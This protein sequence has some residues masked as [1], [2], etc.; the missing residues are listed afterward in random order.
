MVRQPADDRTL[1][2]LDWEP[3][4]A[5]VGFEDGE[6]RGFDPYAQ[7]C[8]AMKLALA[9]CGKSRK[10]VAAAMS[11]YLGESVSKAMLDAYVSEGR[12][13][14]TINVVRVAAFIDATGDM[15]LLA[16]LPKLFGHAVVAEKYVGCIRLA[17]LEEHRRD[18][19]REVDMTRR[20]VRGG[21]R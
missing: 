17:M 4:K 10:E 8:N 6:V 21:M 7:L 5:D 9:E 1:S 2:L 20:Q 3:P 12:D 11:E 14:H 19:E 16:L 18:I 13:T 15:R